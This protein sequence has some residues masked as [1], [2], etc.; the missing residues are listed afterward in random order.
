M[1]TY[2][3]NS[4]K[5]TANNQFAIA[6]NSVSAFLFYPAASGNN[7]NVEIAYATSDLGTP[8]V[9][10]S[11]AINI[12]TTWGDVVKTVIYNNNGPT[13]TF[14]ITSLFNRKGNKV[15]VGY[16]AT[17][18]I[19]AVAVTDIGVSGAWTREDVR[20]RLLGYI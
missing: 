3:P 20:K 14:Y 19:T 1:A 13:C 15:V 5:A 7:A 6:S 2:Y 17:R 4:L 16:N 10:S 8:A 9:S 11:S 18:A 12:T